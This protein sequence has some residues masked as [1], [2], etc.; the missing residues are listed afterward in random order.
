MSDEG[1]GWIIGLGIYVVVI[2]IIF[3]LN[4][5]FTGKNGQGRW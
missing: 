4:W 3:G 1:L 2:S 5:I